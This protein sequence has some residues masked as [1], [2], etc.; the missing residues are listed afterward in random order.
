[1]YF[2]SLQIMLFSINIINKSTNILPLDGFKRRF[3]SAICRW[4]DRRLLNTGEGEGSVRPGSVAPQGNA[5]AP[6]QE[7]PGSWERRRPTSKLRSDAGL[8]VSNSPFLAPAS[9]RRCSP[10]CT[11]A[12]AAE[13]QDRDGGA[14]PSKTRFDHQHHGAWDSDQRGLAYHDWN[15]IGGYVQVG[16]GG[17]SAALLDSL[18]FPPVDGGVG[19][20][21]R[22]NALL[23]R[24]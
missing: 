4:V 24:G 23:S 6:T 21:W 20:S 3:L 17:H 18:P 2:T 11:W 14:A 16:G 7:A 1:M 19:S 5:A 15:L 10:P 9:S 22:R 12:T 8:S 13:G